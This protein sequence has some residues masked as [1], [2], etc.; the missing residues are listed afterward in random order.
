MTKIEIIILVLVCVFV[1]LGTCA[2]ISS[3]INKLEKKVD[4]LWGEIITLKDEVAKLK[5]TS[6]K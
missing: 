1:F 6:I 4:K 5:N 2:L 3:I